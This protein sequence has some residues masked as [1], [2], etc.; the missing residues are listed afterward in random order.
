[1]SGRRIFKRPASA[2]AHTWKRL[3]LGQAIAVAVPVAF[4]L[5][6]SSHM[7]EEPDRASKLERTMNLHLLSIELAQDG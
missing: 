5:A 3:G 4:A 7:P 1:M 2:E 6:P